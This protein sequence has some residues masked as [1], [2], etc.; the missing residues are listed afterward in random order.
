MLKDA[1]K[2]SG[3]RQADV[4]KAIGVSPASLSNYIAGR[5]TIPAERAALLADLLRIPRSTIRA[6]L[7][8][9]PAEA[10]Q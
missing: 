9:A 1:I 4:A 7:W 5:Q 6:D 8:P 2:Q 10:T 3:M